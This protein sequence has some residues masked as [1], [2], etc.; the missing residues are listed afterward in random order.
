M[1]FPAFYCKHGASSI[2]NS[3]LTPCLYMLTAC[4]R[5]YNSFSFLA[6]SS[7]SSMYIKRLI[8][9][10]DFPS[11]YPAVHFLSMWLSGIIAIIISNGDSAPPGKITLLDFCFSYFLQLSILLSKFLMVCSI[12]FMT[13]SNILYIWWQFDIPLCGTISYAF[14]QSIQAIARFFHLVLLS[15][16]I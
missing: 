10:C 6:N 12:K 13:S 5:I 4:I 2:P 8:F 14:L 3:I 15:F 9:F 7:M 1:S 16:R 11:L